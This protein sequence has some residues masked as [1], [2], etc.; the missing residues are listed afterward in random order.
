MLNATR[1]FAGRHPRSWSL[2]RDFTS[3]GLALLISH[4]EPAL[5]RRRVILSRSFSAVGFSAILDGIA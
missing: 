4:F 1:D 2:P 5:V 3:V